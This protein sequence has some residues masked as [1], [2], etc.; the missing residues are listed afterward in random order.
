M[1]AVTAGVRGFIKGM[2][3]A[4]VGLVHIVKNER[5][6]RIHVAIAV[7]VLAVGVFLGVSDEGL[8]ALFFAI[9][10]VFLAEIMNTVIEKTLDL[11]HP[12]YSPQVKLIK[13]M[14][15]GAVL[16]TAVGAAAIGVAVLLPYLGGFSWR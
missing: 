7:I 9:V 4:S 10:L 2:R 13:D 3:D 11:V 6:A 8:A 16:V 14:G 1:A 15:A 12:G 5:N